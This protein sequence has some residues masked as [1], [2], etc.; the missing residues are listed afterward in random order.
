VTG[1]PRA[2][3]DRV[4]ALFSS[5][6]HEEWCGKRVCAIDAR[7]KGIAV[8]QVTSGAGRRLSAVAPRR[9]GVVPQPVYSAGSLVGRLV[10]GATP[11][12][13]RTRLNLNPPIHCYSA[14]PDGR[15]GPI[16]NALQTSSLPSRQPST[17]RTGTVSLATPAI[18]AFGLNLR[19][20]LGDKRTNRHDHRIV[21]TCDEGAS[22]G[23]ELTKEGLL[24]RQMEG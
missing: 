13:P 23:I 16:A 12:I 11:D 2:V 7:A 10:A 1:R 17:H 22:E 14:T 8:T 18:G 5:V 4:A 24:Q 19:I 15:P 3:T 6:G 9:A 21:R 20:K